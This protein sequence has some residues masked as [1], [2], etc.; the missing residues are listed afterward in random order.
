MAR[1]E[2]Y[3]HAKFHLDPGS[4]LATKDMGRKLWG[5]ALFWRGGAGSP[6][7]TKSPCEAYLHTKWHLNSSS[8]FSHNYKPKIG[9]LYPFGDGELG[10]HLTQRGQGQCLPACQVSSGSV[11]PFGHGT[12]TFHTGQDRI[13]KDR[14]TGQTT[15][16][17]HRVN[18]FTNGRPKR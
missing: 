1:A 7:N 2:A 8:H 3:L 10:P 4:R 14:Q 12:P 15:V 9:R 16:R 11:P 17:W 18:R 6:S 5:S 13:G